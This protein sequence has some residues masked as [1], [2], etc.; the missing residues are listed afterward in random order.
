MKRRNFLTAASLCSLLICALASPA[1][2]PPAASAQMSKATAVAPAP[3]ADWQSKVD[4]RVLDA[5]AV[6]PAEFLVYMRQQ[7]DLS[8]ASALKGKAEKGR[9]VYERLTA[10]AATTQSGVRRALEQFGATYQ[11]FWVSNTIHARGGAAV[12]QAVAALP[13]VAAIY[14]VGKGRLMLPPEAGAA[15]STNSAAGASSASLTA[16]DPSPEPGL[17]RVNADDVWALGYEG[18]GVVVAGADTG[19]RWTHAALKNRY[20]GWNGSTA[21]HDY[22]WHDSIHTGT[23]PPDPANICNGGGVPGQPSAEPCDDDD[24][25]GGGHG[26]HTVGTMAG[27]DGGAN[28]IGMAPQAKWV[29]CR[30]MERGV[31]AVPTY[32]ECMEWFIAPTKIDGT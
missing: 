20:R 26:S 17:V 11:T 22:N 28:R 23:W 4:P 8:A 16:A 2:P 24:I 30:N 31:G 14:P 13:E 1:V 6:G 12:V 25:V 7:A 21:S 27:D 3:T 10:T 5:L 29:A 32:L 19:V 15:T 18:Q 9:Y